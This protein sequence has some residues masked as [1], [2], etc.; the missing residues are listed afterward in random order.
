MKSIKNVYVGDPRYWELIDHL[1]K[2]N[3]RFTGNPPPELY[4]NG[5]KKVVKAESKT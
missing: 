2:L 1:E 3:E 4:I 5:N